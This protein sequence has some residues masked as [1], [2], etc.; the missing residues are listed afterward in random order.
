MP[1]D[2]E[3]SFSQPVSTLTVSSSSSSWT[4]FSK[5]FSEPG[6]QPLHTV[7]AL[8]QPYVSLFHP[9][10]PIL[11]LLVCSLLGDG[12]WSGEATSHSCLSS[13]ID[14]RCPC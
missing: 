1:Q 4:T 2:P 11:D 5:S 14:S 9:D 7:L 13:Q 6:T 8:V 10:F 3:P 12:C